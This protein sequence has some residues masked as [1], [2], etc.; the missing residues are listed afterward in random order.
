MQGNW[1][2][3]GMIKAGKAALAFSL[4]MLF[5][6]SSPPPGMV[7]V[8]GGEFIMGS[9]LVDTE[10]KALQYGSR[11]PW[12]A[13]ERPERKLTLGDFYIDRTEVTNREYSEFV[14][15][16]KRRAPLNW[17]GGEYPANIAEH[18]VVRISWADALDYCKWRKK[19]LP[20]EAEWEKA[21][22][23][24]DGRDFPWGNVF[25][26]KKVNTLGI[27]GGATPVG[28][29]KDGASP[30]G[31]LD[32]AGNV[33]EWTEDWYKPYPGNDYKD[34]DYGEKF[35]VARG[36]GWGGVGHYNLQV[37]VRSAYRNIAPPEGAF[38][39]VGLRCVWSK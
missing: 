17:P 12:Y 23:G 26:E 4:L 16:M 3:E 13:N 35:K 10:A 38:D 9:N 27:Y 19:R 21:A 11:K 30:Y 31:A 39:D 15:A 14:D 32:M 25:D 33:Q 28:T 6:C 29:F 18:P 37:Y 20:T 7:H 22:R 36:G 34:D 8:P 2:R 24:A 5:G 1:S